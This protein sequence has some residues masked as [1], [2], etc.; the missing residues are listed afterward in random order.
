MTLQMFSLWPISTVRIVAKTGEAYR[1]VSCT[2]VADSEAEARKIAQRHG[3][4]FGIDWRDFQIVIC[5]PVALVDGQMPAEG[6]YVFQKEP[7]D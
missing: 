6:Y 7:E 3:S 1:F 5:Q 4:E 2:V